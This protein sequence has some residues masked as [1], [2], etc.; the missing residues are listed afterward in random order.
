MNPGWLDEASTLP[1]AFAQVREDPRID[2]H[3]V[4]QC[5]PRSRALVVGSGGC[6]VV[7]LVAKANLELLQVVDPNPAQLAL[8]RFKLELLRDVD[9][10]ARLQI[11]GH[12]LMEESARRAQLDKRLNQLGLARDVFGPEQMVSQQGVDHCGR[13]EL[14]FRELRRVLS[15]HSRTLEGLVQSRDITEQTKRTAE[16]GELGAALDQALD[17]VFSLPNLVALFG[18]DAT[19]NRVEDFSRHFARRIRSW[20]AAQPASESPWL[21]QMLVGRFSTQPYPWL[22]LSAPTGLPQIVWTEDTMQSVLASAEAGA[23]DFIHLS[24]ILDWLSP[25]QS[26]SL[27]DH[28]WKALARGGRMVIRQLNS[29]LKIPATGSQ[30]TWLPDEANRL[31]ATD[32]SFF[33]RELHVGTKR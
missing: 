32:R 24:N 11:L 9:H 7:A 26:A 18:P 20:L 31:H 17:Q 30:F 22:N 19:A 10:V 27:L 8:S 23:F 3:L 33:Y 25:E 16:D 6:T 4:G 5:R 15:P 21:A 12:E 2:L 1:V 28:A 14:L 29:A 13:Y